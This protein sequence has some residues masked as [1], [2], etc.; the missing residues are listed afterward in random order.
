MKKEYT[1][2]DSK[3]V[4]SKNE[5]GYQEVIDEMPSAKEITIITYNISDKQ[6][7]LINCLKN[8]SDDC[9]INIITNIPTRWE[10][11]YANSYRERARQKINFYMSKLDPQKFGNN[12]EVL[13]NFSNHGKIIMTD[14]IV[15]IGSEK[16]SEESEKNTEFG[17]I[18]KDVNFIGY[19]KNVIFEDVKSDS[20]TYYEYNYT[21]LLFEATMI[22]SAIFNA[23]NCLYE[24]IY[25][26]HDDIDGEWYYYN[27]TE[28][29]LSPRTLDNVKNIIETSCKI[30]SD[31]YDAI[32]NVTDSD[33]DITSQ[34]NDMYE[35]LKDIS[36]KIEELITSDNIYDLSIFTTENF[37]DS[38]LQ[39]EYAMEAYEENLDHCIELASNTALGELSD[40]AQ[41]AR[42]DLDQLLTNIDEFKSLYSEFIEFFK[43]YHKKINPIIDNTTYI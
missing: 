29:T 12:V 15:Y 6:D 33:E 22:I 10:Y 39:T 41:S 1:I 9:E 26:L 7:Y 25:F 16:F 27:D 21:S 31:I 13:F 40:L 2:S 14:K 35:R 3:F 17:I 30:A 20:A 37:I 24:E 11:Y 36:N 4:F 19:L 42:E 38:Q 8:T 32:D 28:A 34:A 23:K 18:S 5:L 43:K